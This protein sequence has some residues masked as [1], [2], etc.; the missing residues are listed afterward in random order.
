MISGNE[1][2]KKKTSRWACVEAVPTI[3]SIATEPKAPTKDVYVEF[4]SLLNKYIEQGGGGSGEAGFS[5]TISISPIENG[6]KMTIV[7]INGEKSF[8]IMN[9]AKGEK[10]DKGD[11]GDKGNDGY[12]PV[13]EKDYWTPEDQSEIKAY[14]DAQIAPLIEEIN[15][16]EEELILINEGGVE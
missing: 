6:Y 5:P 13:R 3:T 16:V 15:G 14:C 1:I 4:M 11:Q 10:G 2:P 8:N 9:G 12:T 7:D